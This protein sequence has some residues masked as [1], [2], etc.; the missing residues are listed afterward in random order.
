MVQ[1]CS[2]LFKACQ[3]SYFFGRM[4][5]HLL[6]KRWEFTHGGCWSCSPPMHQAELRSFLAAFHFPFASFIS[7]KFW[8]QK[9]PRIERILQTTTPIIHCHCSWSVWKMTCT[10]TA[11]RQLI[12]SSW[13]D[14]VNLCQGEMK[15]DT[16]FVHVRGPD[17]GWSVLTGLSFERVGLWVILFVSTWETKVLRNLGNVGIT[18]D[19]HMLDFFAVLPTF[20]AEYLIIA[21]MKGMVVPSHVKLGC[22]QWYIL[23][24]ILAAPFIVVCCF[25]PWHMWLWGPILRE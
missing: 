12:R 5:I 25:R 14:G 4:N 11:V 6:Q 18:C 20:F 21:K 10:V 2:N 7:G 17:S 13:L 15:L 3:R 23:Q 16:N 19:N 1:T 9:L 22:T 8:G 24:P